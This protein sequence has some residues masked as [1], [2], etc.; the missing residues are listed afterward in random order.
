MQ[1][2]IDPIRDEKRDNCGADKVFLRG[3][4]LRDP[5]ARRARD[6]NGERI[7]VKDRQSAEGSED[8]RVPS[9]C[10]KKMSVKKLDG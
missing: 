3:R 1:E 5:Q 7:S 4:K 8:E 2:E 9:H 10:R 6:Q